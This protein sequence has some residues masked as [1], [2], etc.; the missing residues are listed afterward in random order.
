MARGV[1]SPKFSWAQSILVTSTRHD[2]ILVAIYDIKAMVN[3]HKNFKGP[4]NLACEINIF[5]FFLLKFEF[6]TYVL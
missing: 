4:I 3:E 6:Q 5:C 2:R 1:T